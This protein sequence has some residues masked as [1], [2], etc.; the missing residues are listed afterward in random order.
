MSNVAVEAQVVDA[1]NLLVCL[2]FCHYYVRVLLVSPLFAQQLV[3]IDG[4]QRAHLSR[5]LNQLVE[6]AL[7]GELAFLAFLGQGYARVVPVN[8]ALVALLLV[9]LRSHLAHILKY[10][11]AQARHLL[12]MVE[13]VLHFSLEIRIL[14]KH[15]LHLR[16]RHLLPRVVFTSVVEL[17]D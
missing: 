15:L 11:R 8:D 6:V 4:L 7:L 3:Q 10:L 13:A 17:S 14:G 1:A 12:Q 2:Y 5:V 9:V 16:R